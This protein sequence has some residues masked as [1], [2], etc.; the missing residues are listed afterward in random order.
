MLGHGKN[1]LDLGCGPGNLA[2]LLSDAG[3]TVV[4]VDSDESSLAAAS[5]FCER[6]VLA[7]LR[8]D[9][10]GEAVG[11]SDFDAV[12]LADVIEHVTN[13][14]ALLQK[15]KGFLRPGGLLYASIPN[16]AHGAVRLALLRGDFAYTR[17][18]IMDETHVR[19]YTRASIEE[20]FSESG[21][22]IVEMTR[23]TAPIFVESDLVPLVRRTDFSETVVA[24]IERDP[25]C[26]TLQFIIRAEPV[27][28]DEGDGAVH[29][30]LSS[31]LQE[32]RTLEARYAQ[33]ER[34]AAEE[35]AAYA[36]EIEALKLENKRFELELE[37]A[38]FDAGPAQE[39]ELGRL[40]AELAAS[41]AERGGGSG[42]PLRGAPGSRRARSRGV[43][44][45]VGRASAR[46]Q[47][48]RTR[49]RSL[50]LRC[51]RLAG[52]RSASA[53]G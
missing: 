4:G 27:A 11:S 20:L 28:N 15:T 19:F 43:R 50:S 21:Y 32:V 12:V 16:V 49:A 46:E 1:V 37:R 47:A 51:G 23:T 18:G 53:P 40:A 41:V 45:R 10:L 13:P 35:R 36:R 17:I 26:E 38:R 29:D 39:R 8:H 5:A 30:R 9:S 22:R 42:R 3:N 6:V 24:E 25:E 7:D 44:P 14:V 34:G 48:Y 2:R 31:A 33:L 52:P